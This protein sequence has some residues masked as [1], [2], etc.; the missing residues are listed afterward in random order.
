MV[1]LSAEVQLIKADCAEMHT[2]RNR[3]SFFTVTS[4]GSDTEVILIETTRTITTKGLRAETSLPAV[5]HKSSAHTLVRP[6]KTL[7]VTTDP[8]S[9]CLH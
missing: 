8:R 1:Q 7:S 5:V 4:F 3:K 9:D 2:A 6:R